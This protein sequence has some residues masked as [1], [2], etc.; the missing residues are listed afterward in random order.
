MEQFVF[1]EGL[2]MDV[3]AYGRMADKISTEAITFYRG[4][5]K[6]VRVNAIMTFEQVLSYWP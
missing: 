2:H 3:Q 4:V 5:H 1:K 6:Y